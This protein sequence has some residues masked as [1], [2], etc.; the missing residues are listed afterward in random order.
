MRFSQGDRHPLHFV[1]HVGGLV[2]STTYFATNVALARAVLESSLISH[3]EFVAQLL[4]LSMI[5]VTS[6]EDFPPTLTAHFILNA[7]TCP[8]NPPVLLMRLESLREELRHETCRLKICD[9]LIMFQ[10]RDFVRV[11]NV[12]CGDARDT[13]NESA[14]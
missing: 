8:K 1:T 2:P 9:D 14:S 10:E 7:L 12:F 6:L 13:C 3:R 5:D 4:R 11:I